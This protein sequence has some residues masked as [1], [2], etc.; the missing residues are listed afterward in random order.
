MSAPRNGP[1]ILAAAALVAVLLGGAPAPFQQED[2][3]N[4]L[5]RGVELLAAG[6]FAEAIEQLERAAAL[7]PA[8]PRA[9]YQLGLALFSGGRPYDAV[10]QLQAALESTTDAGPIQFLLG[11]ALLE[12][13]DLAAA[14][15]AL[16]AAAASRPGYPPI[17][18]YR[19]E[20]CYR[21]GRV[22]A[23]RQRFAALAA[24]LPEWTAPRVRSGALAL[25]QD[26]PAVAVE[27]FRAVA[28]ASP[29]DPAAWM[30]LGSALVA[31]EQPYEALAA[32]RRAAAVAPESVSGLVAV[33]IQLINLDEHDAAIEALG[34]VLAR[35]PDHGLI[36]YHRATLIARAGDHERA[37]AEIDIALEDLR[38]SA[39]NGGT[40]S[41]DRPAS[42]GGENVARGG[43]PAAG[44]EI[45]AGRG[46]AAG[47]EVTAGGDVTAGGE[48]AAG[49]RL[50]AAAI[51]FR[52]EQ[53]VAV[54]RQEE[55]T[56]VARELVAAEPDYPE[57]LFLLGNT[58][59]RSGD[60]AGT[61][62]LQRFRTLSDA[63]EH[64]Q[65][66]DQYLLR[67]KDPL[68]AAS[69]YQRAVQAFPGDAAAWLGLAASQRQAGVAEPA[70]E[71]LRRAR[72]A[73]A[74]G[75]EWH[76]ERVLALDAAGRL[77]EARA[78]WEEAR[79]R[80]LTLGPR[81]WAIVHAGLDGC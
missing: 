5:Q 38:E 49:R 28:D 47:G 42:P 12:T 59:L 74:G 79:A 20:L 9:R 8:D 53:L 34:A 17:D 46:V 29:G 54:G 32:Y 15:T 22:A 26:E 73:G 81:V 52:A 64:R 78:A 33:A 37:L 23:A 11:Q 57:A 58:L 18:F 10:P 48:V 76:R 21:M 43:D 36:R 44:G 1:A 39:A 24:A 68:R 19:A 13:G 71:S 4:Y 31:D 45:A 6:R 77:D 63:R 51:L 67:E 80:G 69:A 72:A 25:E 55:A 65:L 3:E 14:R 16:A 62:L 50:L 27:W 35:D 7:M 75:V 70:L 56:A 41:P 60:P 2:G 66:G 30:R 61:E 40:A